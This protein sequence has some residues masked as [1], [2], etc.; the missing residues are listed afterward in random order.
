MDNCR[1]HKS[2][3]GAALAEAEEAETIPLPFHPGQQF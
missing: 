2:A 1:T 3:R